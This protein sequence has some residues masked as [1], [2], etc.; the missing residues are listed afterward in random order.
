VCV[1]TIEAQNQTLNAEHGTTTVVRCN[2][3][4]SDYPQWRFQFHNG[5]FI[6][7]TNK[8]HFNP[9]LSSF[10]R[11]SWVDNKHLQILSVTKTDEGKYECTKLDVSGQYTWTIQLQVIGTYI[12]CSTLPLSLRYTYCFILAFAEV[13]GNPATILIIVLNTL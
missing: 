10:N 13:F 12:C 9:E 7:V 1:P 3:S 8:E 4:V 6:K 2:L 11:T 5:T